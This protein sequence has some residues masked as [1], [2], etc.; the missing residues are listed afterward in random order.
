MIE[1]VLYVVEWV[2]GEFVV[3][4]EM[5]EYVWGKEVFLKWDNVWVGIVME[6]GMEKGRDGWGGLKEVLG[7]DVMVFEEMG[8]R[9]GKG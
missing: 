1:R 6:E 3:G 9:V 5:G 4:V 2:Y 8:E 7:D